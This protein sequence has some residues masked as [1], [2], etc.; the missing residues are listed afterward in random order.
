MTQGIKKMRT[1]MAPALRVILLALL[2]LIIASLALSFVQAVDRNG[3]E[4]T[5]TYTGFQM[6]TGNIA[7]GPA[8]SREQ[9]CRAVLHGIEIAEFLATQFV[10]VKVSINLSI[11]AF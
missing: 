9:A 7:S 5:L 3:K 1:E 4:I 6:L 11:T 10:S 8:M 2:V